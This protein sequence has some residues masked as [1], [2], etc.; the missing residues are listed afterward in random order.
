MSTL[1]MKSKGF[2]EISVHV[3]HSYENWDLTNI[4]ETDRYLGGAELLYWSIWF[5]YYF[6]PLP[7]TASYFTGFVFCP[8]EDQIISHWESYM[9]DGF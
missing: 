9:A 1:I 4:N 8:Y 6:R 7:E 5:F 2:S 3:Y